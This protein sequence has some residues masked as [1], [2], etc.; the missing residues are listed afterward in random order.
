MNW[1]DSTKSSM[2]LL[3]DP[4]PG[5]TLNEWPELK[6]GFISE[7][8]F[9]FL[10]PS[11]HSSRKWIKR[12]SKKR[13]IS[14]CL[15]CRCFSLPPLLS[16]YARIQKVLRVWLSLR[17]RVSYNLTTAGKVVGRTDRKILFVIKRV[18]VEEKEI[19]SRSLSTSFR[20]DIFDGR[21]DQ[22]MK[23]RGIWHVM[24]EREREL[25]RKAD[26]QRGKKIDFPWTQLSY[27][28]ES[29]IWNAWVTFFNCFFYFI[30][31]HSKVC[32]TIISGSLPLLL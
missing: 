23:Y 6:R 12:S 1:P 25:H 10:F 8:T 29:I 16:F 9:L 13:A 24:R 30:L 32:L 18:F 5:L 2:L 15:W 7:S 26:R 14:L 3:K 20:P 21:K 31:C 4:P 27:C 28:I 19:K 11:L 22:R 17:Q